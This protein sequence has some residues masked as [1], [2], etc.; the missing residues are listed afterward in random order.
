MSI[1][2]RFTR[3]SKGCTQ[4]QGTGVTRP[5][6]FDERRT[7]CPT[8]T[9]LDSKG[10]LVLQ[11]DIRKAWDGKSV[12]LVP[13]LGSLFGFTPDGYVAWLEQNCPDRDDIT[14]KDFKKA[15]FFN[16]HTVEV[17]IDSAGRIGVGRVHEEDLKKLGIDKDV[18]VVGNGSHFEIWDTAK[19]DAEQEAEESQEFEAYLFG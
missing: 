10:R 14:S 16:A 7:R 2:V 5:R 19:W 15:R 4:T 6:E 12:R 13:V 18:T 3:Y 17:E 11:S 9:T 1:S 8:C